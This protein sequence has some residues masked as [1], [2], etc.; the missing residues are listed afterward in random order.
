[1]VCLSPFSFQGQE[2]STV[3]PYNRFAPQG[4][5]AFPEGKFFQ[6]LLCTL[7]L[8]QPSFFDIL[9]TFGFCNLSLPGS[10]YPFLFL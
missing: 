3:V 6:K 1:M 4:P 9:S 7:M 10:V 5:I 2:T 8:P